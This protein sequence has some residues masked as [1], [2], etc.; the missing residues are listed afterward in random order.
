MT[1]EAAE[2]KAAVRRERRQEPSN[3]IREL[4]QRA[5]NKDM[6]GGWKSLFSDQRENCMETNVNCLRLGKKSSKL[7]RMLFILMGKQSSYPE[8]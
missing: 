2:Q 8:Q 4:R 5:K 7:P 6:A 1:R 3:W